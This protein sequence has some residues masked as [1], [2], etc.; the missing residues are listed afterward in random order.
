MRYKELRGLE[1]QEFRSNKIRKAK[2]MQVL[3][4]R[5]KQKPKPLQLR[6]FGWMLLALLLVL[7]LSQLSQQATRSSSAT[8]AN[9]RVSQLEESREARI[10]SISG[11]REKRSSEEKGESLCDGSTTGCLLE[12]EFGFGFEFERK[13]LLFLVEQLRS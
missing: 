1:R 9:V 7:L 3:V 13:L 4:E 6:C 11:G 12:L 2:K 5:V 10:D 8:S